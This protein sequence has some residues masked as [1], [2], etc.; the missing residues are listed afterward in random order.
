MKKINL[1]PGMVILILI[2]GGVQLL[3][4]QRLVL[5]GEKFHDLNEKLV[6]E[7]KENESLLRKINES[8][9]L[10]RIQARAEELGLVKVQTIV[11]LKTQTPIAWSR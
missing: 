2:L 10:R 8:G 11:Y 6:L 4:S 3:V 9:C 1:L 5:A 7:E